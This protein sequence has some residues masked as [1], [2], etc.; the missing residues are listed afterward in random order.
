MVN[1]YL[2][3]NNNKD[4]YSNKITLICIIQIS[5]AWVLVKPLIP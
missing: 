3:Y 5:I 2:I 4:E 1:S